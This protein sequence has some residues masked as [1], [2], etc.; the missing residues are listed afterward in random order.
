[1]N[2]TSKLLRGL[3]LIS[4]INSTKSLP[5]VEEFIPT[6]Q[7]KTLDTDYPLT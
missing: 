5:V 4:K 1:M 3:I 7:S 2:K 6:V